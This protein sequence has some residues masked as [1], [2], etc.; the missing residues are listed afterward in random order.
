MAL[1]GAAGEEPGRRRAVGRPVR[2]Q[3]DQEP[4]RQQCIAVLL[5]GKIK[6]IVSSAPSGTVLIVPPAS[7]PAPRADLALEAAPARTAPVVVP[8]RQR[9]PIPFERGLKFTDLQFADGSVSFWVRRRE[10]LGDRG[11][12]E[13]LGFVE[14]VIHHGDGDDLA[15]WW[16]EVCRVTGI[17]PPAA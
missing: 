12:Q 10:L 16:A 5:A 3:L 15:E 14:R 6:V 17:A 9:Q 11:L 4:L 8:P 13:D 7:V 1:L 2:P